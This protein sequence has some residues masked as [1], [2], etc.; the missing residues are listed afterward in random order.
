MS[1]MRELPAD[2]RCTLEQHLI[3][4]AQPAEAAGEQRVEG[5]R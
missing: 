2:G 1:A 4:D 3:V 5:R